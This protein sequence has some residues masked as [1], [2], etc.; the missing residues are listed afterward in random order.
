MKSVLQ[1]CLFLCL[2]SLRVLNL[3]N[4]F[5]Q[6]GEV[7]VPAW[8]SYPVERGGRLAGLATSVM[9]GGLKHTT[10]FY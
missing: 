4:F 8:F 7:V 2:N 6:A 1:Y 5:R 9:V 10:L 3:Y